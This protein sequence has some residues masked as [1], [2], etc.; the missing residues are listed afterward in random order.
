MVSKEDSIKLLA[1]REV[2]TSFSLSET[3]TSE[4]WNLSYVHTYHD[5]LMCQWV[6]VEDAL[7]M[8]WVLDAKRE[9]VE[10]I[11]KE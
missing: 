2:L 7:E 9:N 10:Q 8:A 3:E 1:H 5:S 6:A 11:I 4:E